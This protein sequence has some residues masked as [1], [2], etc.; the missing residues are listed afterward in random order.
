[1]ADA[2]AAPFTPE[3]SAAVADHMNTDHPEDNLLIV[4]SL[5]GVPDATDAR[6]DPALRPGGRGTAAQW[7][8]R[9]HCHWTGRQFERGEQ[10]RDIGGPDEGEQHD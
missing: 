1:M 6:R 10:T 8:G 7:F 5:G 9:Q 3:I 4:R 2:P